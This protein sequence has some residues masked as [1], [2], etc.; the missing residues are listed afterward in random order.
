MPLSF[1]IEVEV[2][3]TSDGFFAAQAFLVKAFEPVSNARLQYT[4]INFSRR[5][6]RAVSHALAELSALMGRIELGP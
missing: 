4:E 6:E 1:K 2:E 5:K 3:Q